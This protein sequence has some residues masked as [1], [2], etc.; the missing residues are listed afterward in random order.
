MHD[1]HP[2][3]DGLGARILREAGVEVVE[4]VCEA[5]VRRQLGAWVL[6]HH[7]HDIIARAKAL[8]EARRLERVAAI[9][10]LEDAPLVRWV[11]SDSTGALRRLFGER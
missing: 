6:E 11:E 9:Y 7:P 8:P 3:V 10:S 4:S 5:D 2:R 1:P